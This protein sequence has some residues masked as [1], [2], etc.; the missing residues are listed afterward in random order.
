[1]TL[2]AAIRQDATSLPSLANQASFNGSS[3]SGQ[4]SA[5]TAGTSLIDRYLTPATAAQAAFM[6][7]VQQGE[8]ARARDLA[9]TG[10]TAPANEDD[11]AQRAFW[12][13]AVQR[14][15]AASPIV[16]IATEAVA[17]AVLPHPI[18]TGSTVTQRSD[19]TTLTTVTIDVAA[20]YRIDGGTLPS[21]QTAEQAAS[22]IEQAI[23]RDFS[24]TYVD[25]NGNET[26]YVTD[27]NMTVNSSELGREQFVL[28]DASDSRLDGALGKAPGFED[29]R[30]AYV[31]DEAGARTAPHEFGHLAGLRHTAQVNQGCTTAPGIDIENLM[32]QTGCS[33]TSQQIERSQLEQIFNTPDFR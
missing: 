2:M 25:A 33:P 10:D 13:G 7:P 5:E 4:S 9:G 18:A 32:S 21:G 16:G 6:T 26:R 8:A 30:T 27:V 3:M 31:S 19:G 11:G 12:T 17:N 20:N 23:E 28:V 1:M 29:G 14:A 22:A 15:Y 24:K